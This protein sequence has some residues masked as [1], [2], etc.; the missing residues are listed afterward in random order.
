[1]VILLPLVLLAVLS[2]TGATVDW[3]GG[4]GSWLDGGK[5]SDGAVPDE[6]TV[7]SVNIS[8]NDIVSIPSNV[9]VL[10]LTFVGGVIEIASNATLNVNG[11]FDYQMGT[12]KGTDIDY[13]ATSSPLALVNLL[14][15]STF[16]TSGRKRLRSV[17][18]RQQTDTLTW[19]AGDLVLWKA[20]LQIDSLATLSVSGSATNQL[21]LIADDSRS[22]F[23]FYR[24]STLNTEIDLVNALPLGAGVYDVVMRNAVKISA[25]AGAGMEIFPLAVSQ[26]VNAIEYY[27]K[28]VPD[29]NVGHRYDLYN[30]TIYDVDEDECALL[31]RGYGWCRSYDYF[32]YNQTCGVSVFK[33]SQ[34]GGLT[35]RTMIVNSTEYP[36]S[37]YELRS[38]ERDM[39]SKLVI[40]GTLKV[41]GDNATWGSALALSVE[42]D[43]TLSGSAYLSDY[44]NLTLS[45][46]LTMAGTLTLN[47]LS[48]LDF[49]GSGEL[50]MSEGALLNASG[51]ANYADSD[52]AQLTFSGGTH[53]LGD[54]SGT[55]SIYLTDAATLYTYQ[56]TSASSSLSL[57][58]VNVAGASTLSL[59]G[60]NH[61]T[62]TVDT[63][64]LEG[65][66]SLLADTLFLDVTEGLTLEQNSTI[67]ASN[68][69]YAISKGPGA[70]A[71]ASFG[72]SGGA[73]GGRGGPSKVDATAPAY[74]S[75]FNPITPGSGGGQGYY[76]D[77]EGGAG[78]GVLR[79]TCNGTATIDGTLSSNGEDGSAAGGGGAGGSI[80]L[81]ADTIAGSGSI[82]AS[83]GDGD[84]SGGIAAGGGGSGGRIALI[85]L[86]FEFSGD[87]DV[88][89][90][91]L[92][93]TYDLA[94]M[95][96][97]SPGTVYVEA[98]LTRAIITSTEVVTDY[99]A[100]VLAQTPLTETPTASSS[101]G[102]YVLQS[103]DVC[104][105]DLHVI[106][107]AP[108][109]LASP[110]F[111]L[112]TIVGSGSGTGTSGTATV[113]LESAV[114]AT[115]D[116]FD[117]TTVTLEVYNASFASNVNIT[118]SAGGSLNLFD[119]GGVNGGVY[120]FGTLIIGDMGVLVAPNSTEVGASTLSLLANSTVRMGGMLTLT[121]STV[122]I[123]GSNLRDWDITTNTTTANLR[124]NATSVVLSGNTSLYNAYLTADCAL[125]VSADAVIYSALDDGS[126]GFVVA[127]NAL[128][129]IPSGT[130]LILSTPITITGQVLVQELGV[131]TTTTSGSCGASANLTLSNSY[132]Y[133]GGEFYMDDNCAITGGHVVSQS[134]GVFL[135]PLEVP[136]GTAEVWAIGGRVEF[137]S[138]GV[139][140]TSMNFTT[141]HVGADGYLLVGN[142]TAISVTTLTMDGGKIHLSSVGSSLEVL[143]DL[144]YLREGLVEGNGTLTIPTSATLTLAPYSDDNM[145]TFLEIGVVNWGTLVG[146]NFSVN[147]ARAASVTNYGTISF[148]GAQTWVHQESLYAYDDQQFCLSA[149]TSGVTLYNVTA[150]QCAQ[151][152]THHTLAFSRD[153]AV[154]YIEDTEAT[155]NYFLYNTL[156]QTCQMTQTV[157]DL[158]SCSASISSSSSSDYAWQVY[159]KVPAWTDVPTLTNEIGATLDAQRDSS[160]DIQIAVLNQG[161][162]YTVVGSTL[163]FSEAVNQ[164]ATGVIATEGDITITQTSYAPIMGTILGSGGLKLTTGNSNTTT[165]HLVGVSIDDEE[166]TLEVNG[167]LRLGDN[168]SHICVKAFYMSDGDF[169]IA[170]GPLA[171]DVKDTFTLVGNSTMRTSLGVVSD[172]FYST[173]PEPSAAPSAV[174]NSTPSS[175]R[176]LEST[177]TITN[178]NTDSTDSTGPSPRRL[179]TP[180]GISCVTCFDLLLTST[181]LTLSGTATLQMSNGYIA[182][183]TVSLTDSAKI[184]AT[185][186]G[187][188]NTNTGNVTEYMGV[189]GFLGGQGGSHGGLG[190][191]GYGKV[192]DFD[193]FGDSTSY[194]EF[195]LPVTWGSAG[196]AGG[197]GST[198]YGGG[199]VRVYATTISVDAD[200]SIEADGYSPVSSLA[201]GGA[202]G[203]LHLSAYSL[204]G[205]G[206][207]SAQ[208][209]GGGTQEDTVAWGGGGG[210]GRLSLHVD[211]YSAFSGT[212]GA[213]GG[214]GAQKGSAGTVFIMDTSGGMLLLKNIQDDEAASTTLATPLSTVSPYGALDSITLQQ[215]VTAIYSAGL[216]EVLDINGDGTGTLL[217]TNGT[218]LTP[219]GDYNDTLVLGN[220]PQTL[221]I[222]SATLIV[223]DATLN[224]TNVH[225]KYGGHVALT[226]AGAS[227]M[228]TGTGTDGV[229][230]YVFDNLLVDDGAQLSIDYH[231]IVLDS[232]TAPS[233]IELNF[234]SNVTVL[235][236]GSIH[237][238][239]QGYQG[240]Y[241]DETCYDSS[242]L[243][244]FSHGPGCGTFGAVGGGGGAFGGEGGVGLSAAGGT[245]Y[246]EVSAPTHFGSGGGGSFRA[247]GGNGGGFLSI[248]ATNLVLEGTISAD[249]GTGS[250]AGGG[251]GAGGSVRLEVQSLTGGGEVRAD[252]GAGLYSSYYLGGGGS[253][254]RVVITCTL[255]DAGTTTSGP[256]FT[257]AG[258]VT[259]FGGGFEVTDVDTTQAAIWE[260]G[261]TLLEWLEDTPDRAAPGTVLWETGDGGNSTLVVK[262]TLYNTLSVS[263]ISGSS[264]AEVSTSTTYTL[265][266]AATTCTG[267][268]G[269]IVL[270]EY[271][272]LEV[273]SALETTHLYGDSTAALYIKDGATL[274]LS[275]NLTIA[276]LAIT[277]QGSLLGA[278]YLYLSGAAT[279]TIY[280]NASWG[281]YAS[282]PTSGLPYH[283][284]DTYTTSILNVSTLHLEDTAVLYF[285]GGD[286]YE[287]HRAV[288]YCDALIVDSE[289]SISADGLGYANAGAGT[290]NTL[291]ANDSHQASGNVSY[292]DGGWHAGR[293]GGVYYTYTGYGSAFFPTTW[294]AAGGSTAQYQGGNGG[295][296]LRIIALSS[297]VLKG[298]I[299][300]N[301]V[302]CATLNTD[303]DNLYIA[304]GG[305]G[306][307]I[308]L[309]VLNGDFQGTGAILAAGGNG[310]TRYGGG[311]GSGGRVSIYTAE[312]D[313]SQYTGTIDVSG[314]TSA[315]KNGVSNIASAGGTMFFADSQGR[316]GSLTA[317]NRGL[318]SSPVTVVDSC[319]YGAN[320]PDYYALSSV[321]TSDADFSLEG[322]TYIITA[323]KSFPDS[324]IF[325]TQEEGTGSLLGTLTV[326]DSTLVVLGALSLDAASLTL[327]ASTL[328][329]VEDITLSEAVLTLS[330]IGS[331]VHGLS[332]AEIRTPME[333]NTLSNFTETLPTSGSAYNISYLSLNALQLNAS[334]ALVFSSTSQTGIEE[335]IFI[336][337]YTI[338]LDSSAS[339]SA[340]A[341]LL[342]PELTWDSLVNTNP[343]LYPHYGAHA[344]VG[345]A[346]SGGAHAGPGTVGSSNT[347]DASTARGDPLAPL[348]PGGPGGADLSTGQAGGAGGLGLHFNVSGSM[349]VSGIIDVSGGS[350]VYDSSAGGGAGGAIYIEC[351]LGRFNGTG[352]LWAYGGNGSISNSSTVHGGA[353]SGGRVSIKVCQDEFTG[354]VYTQGGLS[355]SLPSGLPAA[356]STAFYLAH[357]KVADLTSIG[358]YGYNAMQSIIAAASGP[359]L[360]AARY[361]L[362]SQYS[363]DTEATSTCSITTDPYYIHQLYMK[364]WA[365]A[366]LHSD[367]SILISAAVRSLKLT[368]STD[369]TS[370]HNAQST[371][372]LPLDSRDSLIVS[373]F[374]L[375]DARLLITGE[376][377]ISTTTFDCT[378]DT[379]LTLAG[380]VVLTPSPHLTISNFTLNVTEAGEISP[381]LDLIISNGGKLLI[382]Y[383][384]LTDD[385]VLNPHELFDASELTPTLVFD[386]VDV[387][388]NSGIYGSKIVVNATTISLTGNSTFSADGLGLFGGMWGIPPTPGSGLGAGG[389][390][391]TGGDGGGHGGYGGLGINSL[392]RLKNADQYLGS[393]TQVTLVAIDDAFLNGTTYGNLFTPVNYGSGGGAS[394]APQAYG[395]RGGG[396]IKLNL[397]WDIT[398]DST[399]SISADGQG[400]YG[401][402]GGGAGGSIWILDTNNDPID[403]HGHVVGGGR[404]SARGGRTCIEEAC[405]V[406]ITH[407]GGVGGGGRVRIDK[408]LEQYTGMVDVR[409]GVSNDT[410][411]LLVT[412]H[413]GTFVR[414]QAISTVVLGT[415]DG[416]E[417]LDIIFTQTPLYPVQVITSAGTGE[418]NSSAEDEI[419]AIVRGQWGL[420]YRSQG[421]FSPTALLDSQASAL[422]VRIALASLNQ[423]DLTNFGVTRSAV[424]NGH[425][426]S[427]TFYDAIDRVEPIK[428]D[429]ALWTTND[430]ASIA[431]EVLNPHNSTFESDDLKTADSPHIYSSS[432]LAQMMSFSE[433]ILGAAEGYWLNYRTLR[434]IPYLTAGYFTPYLFDLQLTSLK[435]TPTTLGFISSTS[436][437]FLL[438]EFVPN[439]KA[440]TSMPSG[441]PSSQPSD[442][443]SG[444]PSGQ[445]SSQPSAEP[446]GQPSGQ[447]SRQPSS[448]P[449]SQPSR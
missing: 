176:R 343:T 363:T 214:A 150:A 399:S 437:P 327:D 280:P 128:L 220:T 448:Q 82:T 236:G 132:L 195:T 250:G 65:S 147:W 293:G 53:Y 71:A 260:A 26:D 314:G 349:H 48:Y 197:G 84:Y 311:G 222:A 254:G 243:N 129:S 310:C 330:T 262:N 213:Q 85:A 251:G 342:N 24:S 405:P 18:V 237:S 95:E 317:S 119:F 337:A 202:G 217:L 263:Y 137:H 390:E 432:Q 411:E 163:S 2:R 219:F 443:P 10:Q 336:S 58:H 70:G 68:G 331:R 368:A 22:R 122:N 108:L 192:P 67:T 43:I 299:T 273:P 62:L 258:N 111:C 365:A 313:L 235:Y 388:G 385:F 193:L 19:T 438:D 409:S 25:N 275:T 252:G 435:P 14:G 292:A 117:L 335:S 146:G 11:A 151:Q 204:S 8:S 133:I 101:R 424:G 430:D 216:V 201:G 320:E 199:A 156:L 73:H 389:V 89:G 449:S 221:N 168:I 346:A 141:L 118:V 186:R 91:V 442:Q 148:D 321:Y 366:D 286:E 352:Q 59:L 174:P 304:G 315:D 23:D 187:Y 444:Q 104:D 205:S 417:V 40:L 183:A 447:P 370:V 35:S 135:P 242:V 339:I 240:S 165:I 57:R 149:L 296:A 373:T 348:G 215:G 15:A 421:A 200:A 116:A 120:S 380:A 121:A 17:L 269:S 276:D 1:M 159:V 144:N 79:I 134:G 45:R 131:L 196:G 38:S 416:E 90:G 379:V 103:D 412:K 97:A 166:L 207:L 190:G 423:S 402:G 422:E 39:D 267:T 305:A 325:H 54:L 392:Y 391:E 360:R 371:L 354:A 407:P 302:S 107:D 428:I 211:T 167:Y 404:F 5:W 297:I 124:L 289:A 143:G 169:F 285:K 210:G 241:S 179:S 268:F 338:D 32:F 93:V 418:G 441:Q 233:R 28:N 152:C 306:G 427:I 87:F 294:G 362:Q 157:S 112:K 142:G 99:I 308:W 30:S 96:Q 398:I 140:D 170:E 281:G 439:W 420:R 300:A 64:T 106:G 226:P 138:R 145:L 77:G 153:A 375:Q 33:M 50:L 257:F 319:E 225:I 37:H 279:F 7:V 203:S 76:D 125:V 130:H 278:Q 98:N 290:P 92:E 218:V 283:S 31:C 238:D 265:G 312:G 333:A 434:I 180:A 436:Y 100:N 395:G 194:G 229:S 266:D 52:A 426:W 110:S 49:Q 340:S 446:S 393:G 184:T 228:G 332:L 361:W 328:L 357:A 248:T 384:N 284:L 440:P 326:A 46:A 347:A 356:V 396:V 227:G 158:Y 160:A 431:V 177:P 353:G 66:S 245:Y 172:P 13:N 403:I 256:S 253:G 345:F 155:C 41:V 433:D 42:V 413:A 44:V 400:V 115:F 239:A 318:G 381:G 208:G 410:M 69:G 61:T 372:T 303:S 189:Y 188:S 12:I 191:W 351:P 20:E 105:V 83:G 209:G 3:L 429:H 80:Y 277:L 164:T 249:G 234:T 51:S 382:N 232:S 162:I 27:A 6:T 136:Q 81:S 301:G 288:L 224:A 16:S 374:R 322:C 272:S 334:T 34:V 414:V 60:Y 173:L 198:C 9:T 78:G 102:A 246:G 113:R 287:T 36:L 94:D 181:N 139:A 383:G 341:A 109:I 274:T 175:A 55:W 329:C 56:N 309:T 21:Q 324:S 378:L 406:S 231:T 247:A 185:G 323:I 291:T 394:S 359:V 344:G 401:G 29:S 298:T 377:A 230:V 358:D 72:A 271:A 212:M 244:V 127:A 307:S 63:I 88:M 367:P 282:L 206:A 369:V 355:V 178:T 47:P 75:V 397:E 114:V 126:A 350:A 4:S 259:A 316:N 387:S 86:N 376:G 386:T 270:G 261:G 445:P 182:A 255:C 123:L 425:S 161:T 295:G 74:G 415:Q 264:G 419:D 364:G 223:A 154:G 171:L 408:T